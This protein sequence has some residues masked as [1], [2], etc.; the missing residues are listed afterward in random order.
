MAKAGVI[1]SPVDHS[2]SP[3]IFAVLAP[4]LTYEKLLVAPEELEKFV[5]ENGP[6]YIGWNVTLPHKENILSFLES[7]S[8]DA[9][10]IG[11]V[12]VVKG[13]KGYNTDYL[14]IIE[15]LREIPLKGKN[16]LV[17]GAGGAAKAVVY[18]LKQIGMDH[19][20]VYN[21]DPSRNPYL[22]ERID[23]VSHAKEPI[24]LLVNTIPVDTCELPPHLLE[25][26]G[27]ELLYY[28][29]EPSFPGIETISGLEMLIWQAIYTYEIWFG[30]L[31]DKN[32]WKEKIQKAIST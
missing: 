4:D 9:K 6:Q 28:K 10:A 18:A 23:Q 3:S 11:A 17:Y 30:P 26:I 7:L 32:E 24:S 31:K 25:P 12:N 29:N 13:G 20:Y 15:P 14:G 22:G 21:R 27:F 8:P 2:L 16:A 1:G 5:Q 19:V